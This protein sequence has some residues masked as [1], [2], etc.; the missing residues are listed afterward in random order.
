MKNNKNIITLGL[1]G[2]V[3]AMSMISIQQS[4][5]TGCPVQF[6]EE[7]IQSAKAALESGDTE[8]VLNQLNLAQ[9]AINAAAQE[10]E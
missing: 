3:L 10:A 1:L 4:Y 5:S 2:A 8:E 7:H 9:E 6:V